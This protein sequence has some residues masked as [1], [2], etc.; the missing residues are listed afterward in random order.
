MKRENLYFSMLSGLA[1]M[2]S[3]RSKNFYGNLDFRPEK[4]GRTDF[5]PEFF[6][7]FQISNRK[8]FG[9]ET[10]NP[11]LFAIFK[12]RAKNFPVREISRP[13]KVRGF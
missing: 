6:W 12:F 5:R 7:I 4:F 3:D 13:K 8:K 2:E 1:H 9:R 11:K 10:F